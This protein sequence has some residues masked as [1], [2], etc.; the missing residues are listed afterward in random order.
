[1]IRKLR[2]TLSR[3]L[4][5]SPPPAR[6][7]RVGID[8]DGVCYDFVASLQQ[9]LLTRD[10]DPQQLTDAQRWEFYEDWGLSLEEFLDACHR[11]VDAGVV[12]SHGSPFPGTVAALRRLQDAG[13]E[14]HVVTDRSFGAPGASR[15][16]TEAWLARHG[17]PHT[18]L[19]ISAD[20]TVADVE[21][22]IEDRVENYRALD[23]AGVEVYL[24][25]RPWNQHETT[26]R[27][28]ASLDEFAD[29]VIARS[30]AL[31]A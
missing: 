4:T 5:T 10:L 14:L 11:G 8:L 7:L 20:K 16:A 17:V 23:A 26:A 19:T 22:F 25:D 28:V 29:R 3:V 24:L 18:S 1:M 30:R 9:Y 12:F 2:A 6:P 21:L 31:A 13:H 15:Q 27:R